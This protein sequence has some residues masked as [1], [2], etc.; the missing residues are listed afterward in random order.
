MEKKT[1]NV[2]KWLTSNGFRGWSDARVSNDP[3]ARKV[4]LITIS[5]ASLVWVHFASNGN[6]LAKNLLAACAI[7]ALERRADK[8]FGKDRSEIERNQRLKSRQSGIKVRNSLTKAIQE[9][10]STNKGDKAEWEIY[11]IVTNIIYQAIWG[12]DAI[13]LESHL[14]CPRNKSRDYMDV[15][16]LEYLKYCEHKVADLIEMDNISPIFAAKQIRVKPRQIPIRHETT[17]LN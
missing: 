12:V 1:P 17:D 4:K 3:K 7:E 15:D 9:W 10:Y 8:A 6:E 13:S 16:S 11:A 5:D 14:D 2:L